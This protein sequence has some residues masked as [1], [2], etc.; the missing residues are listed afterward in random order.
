MIKIHHHH[1]HPR[2]TLHPQQLHPHHPHLAK[3]K[4][5]ARILNFFSR[6]GG[7]PFDFDFQDPELKS[8]EKLQRVRSGALILVLVAPLMAGSHYVHGHFGSALALSAVGH[9]MGLSPKDGVLPLSL[10]IFG[11]LTSV[12]FLVTLALK[13]REIVEIYRG[14]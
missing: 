13:R 9:A 5:S 4:T 6:V 8:G 3:K 2:G 12:S 11:L 14:M 1:H 10:L 7:I